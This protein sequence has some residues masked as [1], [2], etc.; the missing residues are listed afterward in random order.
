MLNLSAA[1]SK[2]LL[3]FCHALPK[4]KGAEAAARDDALFVVQC[5]HKQR[6]D[7]R[8]KMA[9]SSGST[10]EVSLLRSEFD[11]MNCAANVVCEVW[12]RRFSSVLL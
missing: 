4:I 6:D 2:R 9:E 12:K 8:Q 1:E 5:F 11:A 3:N 7:V 10:M